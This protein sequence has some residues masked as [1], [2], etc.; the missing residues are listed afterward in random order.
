MKI[1]FLKEMYEVTG[2]L[3]LAPHLIH[4]PITEQWAKKREKLN[5]EAIKRHQ[6]KGVEMIMLGEIAAIAQYV[7]SIE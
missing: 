6:I 4:G 7:C 2:K 1:V 5:D 3:R